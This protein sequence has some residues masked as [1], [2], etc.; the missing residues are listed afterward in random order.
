MKRAALLAILLLVPL[1]VR[2]EAAPAANEPAQ[3]DARAP[4]LHRDPLRQ[5]FFGDTHVHTAL[6]FDAVGQ[7]TRNRPRDAYRFARGEAI[8]IQ[9]YDAGGKPLRTIQLRRPLD[10][11]AVTDHAELLGET[12]ICAAPGLPGYDSVVCRIA[13]R[14]PW[15]AYILVNG[16]MMDVAEPTRYSFCGKDGALCR[17]AATEPWQEIQRAAEEFY[18]RSAACRFTTLVG[19]EWSGNPDSKMIHRNV[20]FR[21]ATVPSHPANYIED[22]TGERLWQ[23]L[24]SDCLEAG[25]GCDVL[26]IPHN[27]NLSGGLLFRTEHDDGTP[28]TRADAELRASLEVL[29]EVNQHKGDSECRS[30]SDSPLPRREPQPTGEAHQPAFPRSE[31]KAS[32]ETHQAAVPRSEPQASGEAHQAAAED[33]LCSFEKLPFATMRESALPWTW[34]TPPEN[35]FAREVLGAGLEQ[36]AKLGVNPFKLGLIAA[37]DT[38]LGAPGFTDEDR[39][40]GHAA[41]RFTSRTE[42]PPLPDNW[43]FNP[44]GLAGVWAE[45]NTRDALFDAMRRRE[46]WGTSGPRIVVRFFGG[47]ELP[48]DLCSAHDFAAQGYAHGVPMGGDLAAPPSPAAAPR[49]AVWAAR[50]AGTDGQS[51]T[52]LQRAQIVKVWLEDGS[53]R[54]RVYDVAGDAASDARVDLATCTPQGQG[55]DTLCSTWRDP[56][57]D[58]NTHAL[59]YARVVENPS[60]RWTQWACNAHQVDCSE[61]APDGLEACCDPSVPMTIQERAWT[62]PIWWTPPA[63][64]ASVVLRRAHP[65]ARHHVAP[66]RHAARLFR[67]SPPLASMPRWA[68]S[69]TVQPET[70]AKPPEVAEIPFEPFPTTWLS[71]SE[72]PV[73]RNTPLPPLLVITRSHSRVSLPVAMPVPAKPRTMPPKIRL[74]WPVMMPVDPELAV[75]LVTGTP[76][77]V[78][79]PR[80][81]KPPR[82]SVVSLVSIPMAIVAESGTTRSLVN[83]YEPAAV[84][85]TGNPGASPAKQPAATQAWLIST[86]PSEARAIC[87]ARSSAIA[88]TAVAAPR[89]RGRRSIGSPGPRC[90]RERRSISRRDGRRSRYAATLAFRARAPS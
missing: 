71:R 44:G 69:R 6:S 34:S 56:D 87:V 28:I 72:A 58:P 70:S 42:V 67:T 1:G 2:A 29:L 33:P 66:D 16:S 46:A 35:S 3:R 14:W 54:E 39:F 50:D 74:R 59:Y 78:T 27:A 83:R 77:Q 79:G 20:L 61:G 48:A 36:Q 18:D 30:P 38:H 15:L 62:S 4:C 10:F 57:F 51:G 12:H 88:R 40:V 82:S 25:T 81:T 43:W 49:F 64:G 11:A 21:N 47:F 89:V 65:G 80:T 55:A 37:T 7:G 13:R 41:G 5:P 86:T 68:F 63:G 23:R 8:G 9:P 22:R 31:P 60:C 32:G 17:E 84:M 52:P 90:L 76:V 45:E 73:A 75:Q 53:A 24:R 26:V 19:Y 85:P